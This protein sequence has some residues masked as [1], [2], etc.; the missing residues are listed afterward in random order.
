[1]DKAESLRQRVMCTARHYDLSCQLGL[2]TAYS[3]RL[4]VYYPVVWYYQ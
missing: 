1:M 2:L 3:T 4:Y